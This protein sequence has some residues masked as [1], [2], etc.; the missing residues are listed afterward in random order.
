MTI[1]NFTKTRIVYWTGTENQIVSP[2]NFNVLPT[3]VTKIFGDGDFNYN[4]FSIAGNS[5]NWHTVPMNY[6][7]LYCT[8]QEMLM[9]YQNNSEIKPLNMKCTIGHSIPLNTTTTGTITNLSFNN[10]IYSLIHDLP[11]NDWVTIKPWGIDNNDEE[12]SIFFQTYD[13]GRR[14][15][16]NQLLLPKQDIWFKVPYVAVHNQPITIMST[17]ADTTL[18]AAEQARITT[19]ITVGLQ[20]NN[21]IYL[22][23]NNLAN[24]YLPEVLMSNTHTKAL[25]PGENQ[26]FMEINIKDSGYAT[27]NTSQIRVN[28]YFTNKD[29]RNWGMNAN[30]PFPSLEVMNVVP[31]IQ[32]TQKPSVTITNTNVYDINTPWTESDINPVTTTDVQSFQTRFMRETI[33][34]RHNC[35][36][37]DMYTS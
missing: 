2:T 11:P 12:R 10:T 33:R 19:P 34:S 26:D 32:G 4:V 15:T 23:E 37:S 9:M 25:Y 35:S 3:G 1:L 31:L 36:E 30:M 22:T 5:H 8:N 29:D 21:N 14:D 20:N 17:N 18:T 13:G 24:M 16:K 28:E 7:G 6:Y 27:I